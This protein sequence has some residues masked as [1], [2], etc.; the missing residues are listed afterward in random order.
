MGLGGLGRPL[1]A[2]AVA[3]LAYALASS[4]TASTGRSRRLVLLG[5]APDRPRE[6]PGRR[7]LSGALGR[8]LPRPLGRLLARTWPVDEEMKAA[9]AGSGL[10]PL[11]A[12]LVGALAGLAVVL[13]LVFAGLARRGLPPVWLFA[14]VG[15]MAV[16]GPRWWLRGAVER[17]RS[18]VSRE[19]PKVAELLTLGTESGLELLEAVRMATAPAPGPVGKA[20]Q[21][22][23]IEVDAGRDTVAALRAVASGVGGEDISAFIGA[24]VQGLALGAPIA[25]VLRAQADGLRVKR[26]Q[27]LEAR[28]AGL[29]MKLTVVTILLFVPALF[30]LA[31]LPNLMAFLGGRW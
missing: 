7:G 19:L 20:L 17:R 28:I 5:A 11:D 29:S 26:R 31:I 21:A 30:V 12:Q 9:L 24:L 15:A 8:W 22:A 18:Q 23:L 16:G 3:V 13:L 4:L 25:R 2:L 6:E 1:A 14:G 27:A 10:T